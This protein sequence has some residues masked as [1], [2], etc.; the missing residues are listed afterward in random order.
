MLSLNDLTA[1]LAVAE[2]KSFSRAAEHLHLTQP[3]FS[4]RVLS[5]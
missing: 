1:F 3:A 4:K 5:L 2:L